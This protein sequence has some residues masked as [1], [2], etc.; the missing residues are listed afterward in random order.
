MIATPWAV[1]CEYHPVHQ[2]RIT[3]HAVE[4]EGIERHVTLLLRV[5]GK[6]CGLK[7]APYSSAQTWAGQH[8]LSADRAVLLLKLEV[9]ILSMMFS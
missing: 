7:V 5:R 4:E 8:C 9:R 2:R 1:G 6:K 3:G